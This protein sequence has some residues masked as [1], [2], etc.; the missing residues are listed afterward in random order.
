MAVQG[1]VTRD[2]WNPLGIRRSKL[3]KDGIDGI[4]L[5]KRFS[6]FV[7]D[8][9]GT[10][11]Q[12]KLEVRV[13]GQEPYELGGLFRTPSNLVERIRPGAVVPVKVHP[14]EPR[15]VAIDWDRWDASTWEEVETEEAVARVDAES[16]AAARL[17]AKVAA[18]KMTP[19]PRPTSARGSQPWRLPASST[20]RQGSGRLHA[21]P[22]IGSWPRESSTRRPTT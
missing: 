13:E 3:L 10:G 18:G 8:E 9:G 19:R 6:M 7:D 17:D 5:V 4:A 15:R 1:G 14:S 16:A 22:S 12:F 20:T 2:G 11:Y 21:R